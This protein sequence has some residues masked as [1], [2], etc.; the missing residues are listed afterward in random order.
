[1]KKK[2]KSKAEVKEE[3]LNSL[4]GGYDYKYDDLNGRATTAE[5]YQDN[6][7]NQIIRNNNSETKKEHIRRFIKTRVCI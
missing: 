5:S 6:T 3:L 1:M 7:D 2:R 4:L